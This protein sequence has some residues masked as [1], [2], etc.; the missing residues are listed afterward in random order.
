MTRPPPHADADSNGQGQWE[1]QGITAQR[2]TGSRTQ[3][4]VRWLGY[5]PEEDTWEKRSALAG[6]PQALSDWEDSQPA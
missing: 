5:P 3:F 1:V 4:L 6:A 2:H